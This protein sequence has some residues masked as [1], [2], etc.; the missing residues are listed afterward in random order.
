M[1]YDDKKC[2][3]FDVYNIEKMIILRGRFKKINNFE[4]VNCKYVELL[5][6][7]LNEEVR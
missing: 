6:F 4:V 7:F 1:K 2:D 5:F 3:D